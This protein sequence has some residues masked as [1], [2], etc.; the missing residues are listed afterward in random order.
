MMIYVMQPDQTLYIG[1]KQRE[2]FHHSSFLSGSTVTAAG[3]V[4]VEVGPTA[5]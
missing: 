3:S 1:D 4:C 2:K 5:C